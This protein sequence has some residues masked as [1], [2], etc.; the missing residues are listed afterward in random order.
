MLVDAQNLFSDAQAITAS[1]ASTNLLDLGIARSLGDGERLYVVCLV[2][3]AFTDSGS[4]STV[5]VTI[6]TDDNADF[7]S[8]T[9]AQTLGTFAALS[10][11]GSVLIVPI[12]AFATEE[13]YVRL[14]YT[15]ANGSLTTGAITAFITHDVQRYTAYAD[16]F[17]IS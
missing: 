8:A 13:R 5:A 2:D 14:Y 9:T 11:A 7:S 4:D 3:T 12:A 6:E 15:L 1:A 17:T 16:G 10:A